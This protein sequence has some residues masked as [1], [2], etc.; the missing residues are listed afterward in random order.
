MITA[1]TITDE[2]IRELARRELTAAQHQFC[3]I[4]LGTSHVKS[5][6]YGT[7]T[8]V[9]PTPREI[10]AARARCAALLNVGMSPGNLPLNTVL[11]CLGYVTRKRDGAGLQGKKILRDGV[12]VHEGTADSTWKWLRQTGQIG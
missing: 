4:A 12:V 8:T 3:S 2:Q 1:S 5:T 11:K 7:F 9:T 6:L 10:R